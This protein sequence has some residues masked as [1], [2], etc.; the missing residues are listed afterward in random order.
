MDFE[1]AM[2][3]ITELEAKLSAMHGELEFAR[4]RY[5]E[6]RHRIKNDLQSLMTLASAQAKVARTDYCGR[7]VS[8]L[9]NT[10][11]LHDTLDHEEGQAVLMSTHLA[12]LTSMLMRAF[13]GRFE[14]HASVEQGHCLTHRRAQCV[15][16]I[17]AEAVMNAIKHAFPNRAH[18]NID[19]CFHRLGDTF[20]MTI[21]DNGVG[22]DPAQARPRHGM[23]FMSEIAQQLD[24]AL[25]FK[26]LPVGAMV[27]L[28]FPAIDGR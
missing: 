4:S 17:Y 6:L 1:K 20:E 26:R 2:E 18:G 16:L 22:F 24:G 3:R 7:C 19:L 8:R 27:R 21:S 12:T 9:S 15:G 14:T 13:D 23:R 11:A 10:V 25:E 5:D 28:T